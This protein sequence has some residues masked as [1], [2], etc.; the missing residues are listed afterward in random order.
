M[1]FGGEGAPSSLHQRNFTGFP[2]NTIAREYFIKRKGFT[3]NYQNNPKATVLLHFP[4]LFYD[5]RKTIK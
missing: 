3:T 4:L 1:G 5:K 2:Y